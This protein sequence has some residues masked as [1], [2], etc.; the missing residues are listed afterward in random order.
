MAAVCAVALLLQCGLLLYTTYSK[1][2]NTVAA[3]II[4]STHLLVVV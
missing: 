2:V 4:L 3:L 1:G